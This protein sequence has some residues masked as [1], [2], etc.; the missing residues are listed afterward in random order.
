MSSN[1]NNNDDEEAQHQRRREAILAHLFSHDPRSPAERAERARDCAERAARLTAQRRR[2]DE[3]FFN[4]TSS[5][6]ATAGFGGDPTATTTRVGK[7]R[8][9]GRGDDKYVE[10]TE[11]R[12]VL[13]G[14]HVARIKVLRRRRVA[15]AAA[16]AAAAVG[17]SG[18]A[19]VAR[20]LASREESR[21]RNRR[22]SERGHAE[23]KEDDGEESGRGATTMSLTSSKKSGR[24]DLQA[25][26]ERDGERGME[27]VEAEADGYDSDATVRC[28]IEGL[29]SR[30]LTESEAEEIEDIWHR[31]A[32]EEEERM[33]LP[34]TGSRA[35]R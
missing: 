12:Q 7:V 22:K 21:R 9:V 25:I 33:G 4:T 35:S 17:G 10:W 16:A 24:L 23:E 1:H 19:L 5:A 34:R 2:D 15:M 29:P 27:E 32:D 18:D 20:L 30:N 14:G 6:N 13:I 11:V 31:I 28:V 8:V 26:E 3:L